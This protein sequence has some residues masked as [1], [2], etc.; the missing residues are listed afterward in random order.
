MTKARKS[1]EEVAP[2]APSSA[3]VSEPAL[4]ERPAPWVYLVLVGL[5]LLWLGLA[6]KTFFVGPAEWDDNQYCGLAAVPRANTH[7]PNRYV[8]IWTLRVFYLLMS[9]RRTA[10]ALYSALTVIGLMWVAYALGGG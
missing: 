4:G 3:D 8:H 10:A 2:P 1:A 6:M 9:D 7:V 5:S